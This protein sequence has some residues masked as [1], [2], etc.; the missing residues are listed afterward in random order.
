[1]TSLYALSVETQGGVGDLGRV[2]GVLA[3]Y[4]LTPLDMAVSPSGPGLK[5]DLR[6]QAERR[7]CELCVSRLSAIMAVSMAELAPEA[8]SSGDPP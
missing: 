4:D 6:L 3:L 1:M 5:I 8:F 2:V 7:A